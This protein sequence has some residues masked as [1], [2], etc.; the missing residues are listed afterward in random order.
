MADNDR[1]RLH[2]TPFNP[3][4]LE[5]YIPASLQP[6]AS[7]ISFHTIETF[8]ERGFGYVELPVMEAQKLKKKLNGTT[9]KGAKVKIEEAKPEKKRK[10]APTEDVDEDDAKARKKAKKEKRKREEGVLPGHQ[11][12]EDRHIKRGWAEDTKAKK[13]KEDGEK[14]SIEGKKLRFKTVVPPNKVSEE[15]DSKK[16]KAQ[17]KKDDADKKKK[18]KPGKEAVVKEFAKNLKLGYIS[19][20]GNKTATRYEEGT[21]WVDDSG[22]VIEAEP[23]A[24]KKN[25]RSKK[26]EEVAETEPGPEAEVLVETGIDAEVGAAASDPEGE[27]DVDEQPALPE[28]PKSKKAKKALSP[29]PEE[30]SSSSDS[31]TD[32]SSESSVSSDSASES[33]DSEEEEEDED[34]RVDRQLNEAKSNTATNTSVERELQNSIP[35][36]GAIPSAEAV[37]FAASFKRRSTPQQEPTPKPQKPTPIDTSFNFFSSDPADEDDVMTETLIPQTPRTK[38]DLEWRSTRSAAP[39]PDT[40]AIGKVFDFFFAT[41]DASDAEMEDAEGDVTLDAVAENEKAEGKREESEFRKWFYEN[42]GDLNRAWKKRRREEKK[43]LRQRENR[44]LSRRIA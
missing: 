43:I 19:G 15:K 17:E 26:V 6:Q 22:D 31:G 13:P 4:L 28:P 7:N 16:S 10:V 29:E 1:V 9:L 2:I 24:K 33:S 41:E 21:G 30:A 36:D 14:D 34:E 40:A 11:L 37:A 23:E 18:S 12:A 5:R 42:R 8:P 35:I 27:S 20:R 25:K 32:V 39:T 44:K 3:S 38:E